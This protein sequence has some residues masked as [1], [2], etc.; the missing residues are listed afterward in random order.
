MSLI[1]TKIKDFGRIPNN[2]SN[3][4][5]NELNKQQIIKRKLEEVKK[6]IPIHTRKLLKI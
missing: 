4:N 3:L 6:K 5:N 1:G 2:F